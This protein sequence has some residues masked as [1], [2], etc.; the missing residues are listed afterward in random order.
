MP[1]AA[2]RV[3]HR[4]SHC[5]SARQPADFRCTRMSTIHSRQLNSGAT[6]V[7]ERIENVKS[8]AMNWLLPVGSA[9]DPP[10]GVGWSALL[11]E[12]VFRG[13]GKLD[14]REHSDAL[15]RLGVQ[16]SSDV[17]THHLRLKATVVGE[18]LIDTLPLLTAMVRQPAMPETSLEPVQRLCLSALESLVDDPQH[19]VML[20]LREQHAPPPLN[21]HGYGERRAL[22]CATINDLRGHWA[23]RCVPRG[24]IISAAGAIDPDALAEELNRLLDGWTGEADEPTPASEPARGY[25]HTTQET[26]QVHVAAG[27]DAPPE[28]DGNSM[29]E[30]IGT[31]VLSGSTSAR[32]F[33][34][35]RQKRSLCY[36]VGA[37]YRGNRDRGM[38]SMYAGTTPERAQETLDVS[39]GEIRRLREGVSRDEFDRAVLGLKSHL[40]MSGESTS[41]RAA[42][43]ASDQFRLGRP[44]SLEEFAG[45]IDRV[46]LDDLNDYLARR[47]IDEFTVCTIGPSALDVSSTSAGAGAEATR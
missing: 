5:S 32:L 27:Y 6:L 37:S 23:A 34:E 11:A 35:V 12:L 29:L 22:E 43:L 21:R 40:V 31:S 36:S 24:T 1:H 13:A 47:T 38:V 28:P 33:T 39:L 44:R 46:T 7:A 10:N 30:R 42:T 4:F 25:Q 8:A 9:V 14:S 17:F 26:S 20:K 15:D 41:A 16:R 2:A 45:A 3:D 18:N 19:L